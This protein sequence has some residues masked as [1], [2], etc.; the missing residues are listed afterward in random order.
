[1]TN[2]RCYRL[3]GGCYF[4]TVALAERKGTLLVEHIHALRAAF[5]A[6]KNA[7]TFRL[8]AIVVL[9]DHLHRR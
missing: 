9:P 4:F 6:V 8:E 5:L 1:M 7:N 2:Y 3:K